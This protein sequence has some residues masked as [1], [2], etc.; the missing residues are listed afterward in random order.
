[1]NRQSDERSG[2]AAAVFHEEEDLCIRIES[3]FREMP[4][5][6][7]TFAQAC[8]L[9]GLEPDRG[10][11]VFAALVDVGLLSTDSRGHLRRRDA[12]MAD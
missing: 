9:F 3:E 2:C 11:R 1:M 5:L 4:G 10:E 8:R 6:T 12:L 7:L